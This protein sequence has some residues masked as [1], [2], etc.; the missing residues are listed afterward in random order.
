MQYS[1]RFTVIPAGIGPDDYE[2]GDFPERQ[3]VVELG[4][5]ELA[6]MVADGPLT[7][8][9]PIPEVKRAVAEALSLKAGDEPVILDIARA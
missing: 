4:E 6:G 5:P 3:A 1:V 9:P 8:G 2:P 7:Y